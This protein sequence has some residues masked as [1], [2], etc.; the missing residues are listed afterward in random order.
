MIRDATAPLFYYSKMSKVAEALNQLISSEA[1]SFDLFL[2]GNKIA[3]GGILMQFFVDSEKPMDMN[4]LVAFTRH[5]NKITEEMDLGERKFQLEIS[6]PG[7]DKPLAD[8]RQLAKHVGKTL[9]IVQNDDTELEGEL[10]EVNLSAFTIHQKRFKS[11][12]SKQFEIITH[13]LSWDTC[14]EIKIKLKY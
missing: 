13:E 11:I 1:P 8:S 6:S 5:I 3:P 9:S 14:K 4:N 12:N 7:A 2:V 10:M